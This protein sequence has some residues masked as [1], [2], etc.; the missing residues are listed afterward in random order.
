MWDP[1]TMTARWTTTADSATSAS[2]AARSRMSPCWYVVFVQPCD[3]GSNGRAGHPDDPAHG[4]SSSGAV[5]AAIPISPGSGDATVSP[6]RLS[7]PEPDG[8]NRGLIEPNG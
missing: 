8:I 6:I 4:G 2:T 5:T 1:F 7:F 3:A